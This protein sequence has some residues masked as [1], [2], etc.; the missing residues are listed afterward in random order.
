MK[1]MLI[2]IV[3][4]MVFASPAVDP[5]LRGVRTEKGDYVIGQLAARM[6]TDQLVGDVVSDWLK[7]GERP[8]RRVR[9]RGRIL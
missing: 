2:A 7:H 3:T 4:L 5:D 6:N 9:P 1:K 8:A